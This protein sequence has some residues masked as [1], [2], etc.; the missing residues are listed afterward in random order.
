MKNKNTILF[1][2][3]LTSSICLLPQIVF[4]HENYV[5]TKPEINA[6]LATKG[7]N[8]FSAL[9]SASNL[10][11]SAAVGLLSLVAV[12]LYFLFEHSPLGQKFNS[13]LAKGEPFGHV[14]LRVAL[15]ASLIASANF[16]SFWGEEITIIS[17]PIGL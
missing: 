12:V 14:V 2:S 17:I 7:I 16:N 1:T 11:V 10:R 6:D 15:A 4:A 3:L 8:V 9:N 5:L 13:F